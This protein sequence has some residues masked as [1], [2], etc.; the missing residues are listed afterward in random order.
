MSPVRTDTVERVI[1]STPRLTRLLVTALEMSEV[2][3]TI[4]RN[5]DLEGGPMWIIT[6]DG[7]Y[8]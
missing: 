4:A 2:T 8:S 7:F 6:Q 5:S 3:V 1:V